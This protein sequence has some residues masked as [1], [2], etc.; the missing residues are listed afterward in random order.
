VQKK[1]LAQSKGRVCQR[2]GAAL[3]REVRNPFD[4]FWIVILIC[5]GAALAFYLIGLLIMA[6]GLWLWTRREPYWVCP[7]CFGDREA[8]PSVL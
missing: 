3:Q 7:T 8:T 6:F 1:R 2:C 4:P 5:L